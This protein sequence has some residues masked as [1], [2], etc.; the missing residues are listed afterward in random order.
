MGRSYEQI[1][2]EHPVHKNL[3]AW[4]RHTTKSL[5]EDW[6]VD[7]IEEI[8]LQSR[9]EFKNELGGRVVSDRLAKQ[10]FAGKSHHAV[11]EAV[12]TYYI[13]M[14]KSIPKAGRADTVHLWAFSGEGAKEEK[15]RRRYK[16]TDEQT[17]VITEA[18]TEIYKKESRLGR[19]YYPRGM[20]GGYQAEVRKYVE[21]KYADVVSLDEITDLQLTYVPTLPFRTD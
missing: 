1:P 21:R 16:F 4:I 7:D 18:L 3:A 15:E 2:T 10:Y 19:Q 11:G 5:L 8:P 13:N 6:E 17:R 9:W 14:W 12:K 20:D